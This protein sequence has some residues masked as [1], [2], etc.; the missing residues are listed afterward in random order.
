MLLKHPKTLI[1]GPPSVGKTTLVK[2]I[3]AKLPPQSSTGFY[4]S[5]IRIG[6]VR[7][8]FELQALDGDRQI[9]AHV[10]FNSPWR[11]G[12]RAWV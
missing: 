1:T 12:R 3:L 8:G 7:Q 4:T 6:G 11:Q 10:K 9:L 2:N 5:E